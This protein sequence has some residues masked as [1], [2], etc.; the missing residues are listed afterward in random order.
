ME[1]VQG[2]TGREMGRFR[3]ERKMKEEEVLKDTSHCW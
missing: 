3:R 1:E 2:A